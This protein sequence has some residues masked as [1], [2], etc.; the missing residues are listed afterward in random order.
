[1]SLKENI[2][3]LLNGIEYININI[4]IIND[5]YI[6]FCVNLLCSYCFKLF[7]AFSS[8]SNFL[9]LTSLSTLIFITGFDNKNVMNNKSN[10][11]D[12]NMKHSKILQIENKCYD[13]SVL[14]HSNSVI[15]NN[16]MNAKNLLGE[17]LFS[18]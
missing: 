2:I 13:G 9:F 4:V 5:K 8:F 3:I 1:M 17:H 18:I 14:E 7:F 10:V 11:D 15:K 16:F 12:S 6:I